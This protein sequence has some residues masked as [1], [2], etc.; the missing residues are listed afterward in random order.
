MRPRPLSLAGTPLLSAG[1]VLLA[2]AGASAA[3]ATP[4]L[5]VAAG[6]VR[7]SGG[8]SLRCDDQLSLV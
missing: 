4:V 3:S 8:L 5:D 1:V 7:L 2:L 6:R